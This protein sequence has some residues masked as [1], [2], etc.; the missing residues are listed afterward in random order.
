ML[1]P[2]DETAQAAFNTGNVVGDLACELFPDGKEVPFTRDNDEMISTTKKWLDDG[3]S[4]IYE[5]TFNYGG[6]LVMVDVLHVSDDGVN[7]YEVKSSTEVKDIYLHDVSIQ[8][9]VLKNL[10]F[11]VKSANVVHIN[12]EYVRGEELELEKLFKIVDIRFSIR[13]IIGRESGTWRNEE[14]LK[15]L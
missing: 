10:G 6:I 3:V 11:S 15:R 7:I 14:Y 13:P 1:T 12:K 8:Y 4:N 9:Y 2:P 5:A